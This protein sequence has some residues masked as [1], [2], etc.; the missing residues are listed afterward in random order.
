[1]KVSTL[2][3]EQKRELVKANDMELS[4][5]LN[6]SVVQ[7]ASRQGISPSA[8]MAMRWVVTLKDDGSLKATIGGA[9]FY[10]PKTWQDSDVFSNRIPSISS[11]FPDNSRIT[12]F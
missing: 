9:S 8:L 4:T 11:D 7:A 6:Y 5:F 2:T 12:W 1:M 10:R 3:A